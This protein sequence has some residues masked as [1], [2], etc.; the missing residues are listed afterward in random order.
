MIHN[1]ME[2]LV[3]IHLNDLLRSPGYEN[4]CRC[5]QC[6]DD[7]RAR[8]LNHLEPFYVTGK[9]GEVFGK[10]SAADVQKRMDIIQAVVN[11]VH[12]VSANRHN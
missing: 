8:A 10:Y 5:E 2:D 1:Y 4:I 11:A 3:E 7:I 6:M 12:V 9:K